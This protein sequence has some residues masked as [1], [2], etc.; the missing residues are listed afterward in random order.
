M[1]SDHSKGLIHIQGQKDLIIKTLRRIK[2]APGR[3]K[4]NLFVAEGLDLCK[5]SIQY[6]AQ[7]HAIICTPLFA[8]ST[9]GQELFAIL[10]A[11]CSVYV[12]SLGLIAKCLEAK[13]TPHCL[14]LIHRKT[15]AWSQ[16]L[17]H[18][19]P[20]FLGVDHG[21]FA[22]NLGMV[23][24]SAETAGVTGVVLSSS[25]VDPFGRKVVRGSRGSN[26]HVPLSI[27]DDMVDAIQQAQ[28]AGIQVITT[29][30]NTQQGYHQ[31]DYRK[32]S[33]IIIGNEH[34][35]ISSEVI[36]ASDQCVRIPMMGQVNSL[37]IAVAGSI[38][39]FEAQ[40]Q[41]QWQSASLTVKG[42]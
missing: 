12:C 41:R 36:Q 22:D 19:C 8:R 10:P 23:L 25:T 29:S 15:Y 13:P 35:G 6:G 27:V 7:L 16:L 4:E 3:R 37:N 24:R 31:V 21:D 1:S 9:E 28:Q 18:A 14:A 40:R 30:A 11:N 42:S 39:L 38:M 32:P 20:L 34:K 17:T 5:R 26:F 2:T 33:L